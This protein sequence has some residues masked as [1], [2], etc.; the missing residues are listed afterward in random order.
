M[1]LFRKGISEL[2][3]AYKIVTEQIFELIEK[4][5]CPW[6]MPWSTD[7]VLP[8]VNGISK[9]AYRGCNQVITSVRA[10]H[11]GYRSPQW[12]SEKQGQSRGGRVR[13]GEKGCQIIYAFQAKPK[14]LGQLI[15]SD[16]DR[17]EG[18]CLRY[19][20]VFNIAQ[21]DGLPP[22]MSAYD[23]SERKTEFQ[24]LE[25]CEAIV[26]GFSFPRGPQV[27]SSNSGRACYKP[28]SDT[29]TIPEFGQ[30]LNAEGYYATLFH[31]LGHATGHSTRLARK[32]ICEF[33]FF[34]TENYGHE[35]LVAELTSA[36]LCQ[37]AGI[38][39]MTIENSA[40]YLEGWRRVIKA[41]AKLIVTSAAAAQ[42]ATDFILQNKAAPL[43]V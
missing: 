2:L 21:F 15:D 13:K 10:F 30:F 29:V 20:T 9:R 43:P 1:K 36:F 34:G 28:S 38:D 5:V 25:F 32:G 19:S 17:T 6:R 26:D 37:R 31:E 12:L 4:G 33:D 11:S 16:F 27:V 39:S 7:R 23:E 18:F 42:K 24:R 8:Q 22:E 40:S 35:E 41:D 14:S 3:P